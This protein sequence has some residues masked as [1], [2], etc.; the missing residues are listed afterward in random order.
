LGSDLDTQKPKLKNK[1]GLAL[2]V[3]ELK[4]KELGFRTLLGKEKK[5]LSYSQ[6]LG[7]PQH[8]SGETVQGGSNQNLDTMLNFV[9]FYVKEGRK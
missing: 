9:R 3:V 4:D 2:T 5:L 7:I 1:L 6:L 8:N